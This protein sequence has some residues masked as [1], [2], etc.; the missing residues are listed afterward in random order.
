MVCVLVTG[1]AGYV[2]SH[3]CKALA[4]GGENPV[5]YDNLARGHEWAVKWGPLENGD[6]NDKERLR[7]VM[8][9]HRPEAVIHFAA[10]AYVGESVTDPGLYYRNNVVGTLSLLEIMK[11]EVQIISYAE[12]VTLDKARSL[13][14]AGDTHTEM[15]SK[16]LVILRDL[17]DNKLLSDEFL[18]REARVVCE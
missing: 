9:K 15:R 14:S 13:F 12:V 16:G 3:V 4:A 17:I 7:Q 8:R 1:G 10:Y 2:G 18:L 6:L 5:T 11:E